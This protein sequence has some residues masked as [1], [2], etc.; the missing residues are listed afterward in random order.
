MDLPALQK[1]LFAA[2]RASPP[3]A[4][5]PYAFEKRVL[6]RLAGRP[7]LDPW[8]LWNRIL[9]RAVT[10]CLAVVVMMSLWACF[11]PPVS[12]EDPLVADLERAVYG[13]LDNL[14]TTW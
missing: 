6:A 8:A 4:G 12:A 1:R 14:G 7:V 5:V 3:D 9:W 2:A 10:P 13:P 11:H